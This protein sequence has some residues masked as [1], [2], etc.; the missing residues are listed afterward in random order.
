MGLEEADGDQSVAAAARTAPRD[1]V[2]V[3]R[4]RISDSG[5]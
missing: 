4:L 5:L 1:D 2:L 3:I